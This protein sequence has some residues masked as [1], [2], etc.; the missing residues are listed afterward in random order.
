M[1]QVVARVARVERK[2]EDLHAGK[3]GIGEQLHDLG[4][5]IAEVLGDEIEVAEPAGQHADE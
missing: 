4:R 1:R 3:T 5:G 2:L